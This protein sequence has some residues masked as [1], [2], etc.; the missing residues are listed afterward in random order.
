[1]KIFRKKI[2]FT[3]LASIISVL[4][5]TD[6]CM[7]AVKLPVTLVNG[8]ECFYY[9]TQGSAET[10]YGISKKLG[11]TR[12]EIVAYNPS[13]ADGIHKHITLYFPV[14]DFRDK[15]EIDSEGSDAVVRQVP[16]NRL[17]PVEQKPEIISQAIEDTDQTSGTE[18]SVT[19][20]EFD[21]K[22][23]P[24]TLPTEI[25]TPV[26]TLDSTLYTIAILLPF[27]LE[28]PEL[29]R[30]AKLSTDLY[31]GFLL[32]ANELST[33]GQQVR[34]TPFDV[35]S[36]NCDFSSP[37]IHEAAAII[38]PN[39]AELIARIAQ[40]EPKGYVINALNFSDSLYL[41]NPALIHANIPQGMMYSKAIN[42]FVSSLDGAKPVI[43]SNKE[44]RNDKEA[45]I[46]ALR[47]ELSAK[48]IPYLDVQY[49]GTLTLPDL[50]SL[51]HGT[52]SEYV[53]IPSAGSIGEFNRFS[54]ALNNFRTMHP[55]VSFRLFGY[56]EWL[57]FRGDAREMLCNLQAC[58]YSRFNDDYAS[59]ESQKIRDEFV[60][61]Y[62]A[63]MIES[64]PSQ[65]LLG[66][67][68]GRMTIRNLRDNDGIFDPSYPQ[69]YEG[70]QSTF[71]F[72]KSSTSKMSGYVNDALYIVKYHADGVTSVQIL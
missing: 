37:E 62:D 15:I 26:D 56:P 2:A 52:E 1:M 29:N 64:I 51:Q 6:V 14:S 3:F 72:I 4:F 30:V 60:H 45:F 27:D 44:G 61:W 9:K 33:D 47:A 40:T 34:I 57:A 71:H 18:N 63:P 43:L 65:G 24:V 69:K 41:Y 8:R 70:V 50:E 36:D 7:G 54:Y 23:K 67:D 48:K 59:D 46:E 35:S 68:L 11:L 49:E 42:Y 17:T 10:V 21:N 39:S 28:S 20:D 5:F 22:L 19:R 12:E 16:D 53:I 13:V 32:A 31:R 66:Y 38:A 25:I 58:I 55:H